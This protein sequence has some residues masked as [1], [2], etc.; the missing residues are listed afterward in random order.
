MV[1]WIWLSQI[2]E[3]GSIKTDELIDV[4]GSAENVYEAQKSDYQKLKFLNGRDIQKLCNKSL[5]EAESILSHCCEKRYHLIN[6]LCDDYPEKLRD[7]PAR[8]ILL[9]VEGNL[10]DVDYNPSFSIVGTRKATPYGAKVASMMAMGIA[11]AG[12]IVTSGMANG[13]DT[14]AHKG[15]LRGS[16]KTIAVLGCGLDIC[17]PR[18]NASL[19]EMIAA[20]GCVISEFAPKTQ[21]TKYAFPIRNR[22]IAAL[23]EVTVVVE[24]GIRS[25]S[26]ITATYAAEQGRT[27]YAVPGNIDRSESAGPNRL[28]IDGA[29]PLVT[30]RQLIAETAPLYPHVLRLSALENTSLLSEAKRAEAELL[31]EVKGY[32]KH[33]NTN[34][35]PAPREV[36]NPLPLERDQAP[37]RAA[38]APEGLSELQTKIFTIIGDQSPNLNE[39]AAKCSEPVY[40][41][42]AEVTAL[43]LKKA[44][45]MLPTG[46][47]VIKE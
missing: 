36:Q 15:A 37:G 31:E 20:N 22:I 25:G 35:A 9:Y 40:K 16:G 14:F 32:Q 39:I 47:F 27:V 10:P 5:A 19:K 26:L 17:Y 23:S 3:T 46:R 8:P 1:K 18:E 33:L 34:R 28:I 6:C 30:V 38:A 29:R 41:I 13:I 2:F 7:I 11:Q 45:E 24:A 4:F 43:E 42:A 12:G 21:P 44:I